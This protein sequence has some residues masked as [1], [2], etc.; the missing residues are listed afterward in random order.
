MSSVE[1]DSLEGGAETIVQVQVK[2]L[3]IDNSVHDGGV[4]EEDSDVDD[5]VADA[6]L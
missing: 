4:F 1:D 3:R 6:D 2:D 5:G